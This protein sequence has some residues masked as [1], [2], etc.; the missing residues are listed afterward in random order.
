VFSE[1]HIEEAQENELDDLTAGAIASLGL[2][3]DIVP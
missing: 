3:L 1:K 2:D